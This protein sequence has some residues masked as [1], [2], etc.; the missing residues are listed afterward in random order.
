MGV[1]GQRH[2]PAALGGW[3]G[4]QGQSGAGEDLA[5]TEIQSP[6]RPAR[7]KPLY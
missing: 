7:R 4:L 2:V 1:G 3:V 5:P 6:D